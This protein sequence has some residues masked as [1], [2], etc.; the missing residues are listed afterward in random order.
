LV[1]AKDRLI[2]VPSSLP[3][4]SCYLFDPALCRGCASDVGRILRSLPC[5][6]CFGWLTARQF[7]VFLLLGATLRAGG[8]G[9]GQAPLFAGCARSCTL[10]PFPPHPAHCPPPV[11]TSNWLCSRRQQSVPRFSCPCL[12]LCPGG[13]GSVWLCLPVHLQAP[14]QVAPRPEASRGVPDTVPGDVPPGIGSSP[15]VPRASPRL[16]RS[17]RPAPLAPPLHCH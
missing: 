8:L 4:S 17:S 3:A 14:E 15:A 12:F 11:L 5:S 6:M 16:A 13:C 7:I 10:F 2:H 1:P 9:S